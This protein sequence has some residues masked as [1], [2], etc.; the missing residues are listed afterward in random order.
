[1]GRCLTALEVPVLLSLCYR[2]R[3]EEGI[4]VSPISRTSWSYR[5][6]E[7]NGSIHGSTPNHAMQSA[8]SS[9]PFRSHSYALS[10]FR[11]L[12]YAVA[13]S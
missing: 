2:E 12:T 3:S 11:R 7:R 9:T 13:I 5:G 10:L 6:S 4:G 8:R 1:M